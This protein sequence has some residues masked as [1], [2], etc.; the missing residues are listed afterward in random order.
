MPIEAFQSPMHGHRCDRRT[1]VSE[2]TFFPKPW[3]LF[4]RA[5][6]QGAPSRPGDTLAGTPLAAKA[7]GPDRPHRVFASFWAVLSATNRRKRLGEVTNTS[8]PNRQSSL[9]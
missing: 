5:N 6:F 8:G 1:Q 9:P 4:P 2:G 3:K 7:A